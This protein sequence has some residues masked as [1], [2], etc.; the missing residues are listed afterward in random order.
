MAWLLLVV[1]GALEI[2][3]ALAL[4]RAEGLT[5]FWPSVLGI[6]IA[7]ASLVLLGL[8]LKHLPVGTAY[9]VWVGIGAAGVAVCGMVFL[10]EQVSV[11]RI[12]CLALIGIGV[13]GLR[14]IDG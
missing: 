6:S 2:V 5:R 8:A 1:A 9:A 7:L 12:V 10:G 11:A 13:A 14:A 4:K 3:W